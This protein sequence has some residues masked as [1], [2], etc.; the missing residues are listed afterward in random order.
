MCLLGQFHS[1]EVLNFIEIS[2]ARENFTRG[3][4]FEIAIPFYLPWCIDWHTN[5]NY[6]NS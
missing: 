3:A 2:M 4:P 5:S 6:G 1:Y